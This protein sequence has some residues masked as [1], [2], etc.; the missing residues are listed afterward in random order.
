VAGGNS[1]TFTI[2]DL[3]DGRRGFRSTVNA[4][5]PAGTIYGAEVIE[6]SAGDGTVRLVLGGAL[7][8]DWI[9][10][11]GTQVPRNSNVLSLI[12]GS[13]DAFSASGGQTTWTWNQVS[14]NL[15]NASDEGQTTYLE[16]DGV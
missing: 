6:F 3:G 5:T 10:G 2:T 9:F 11:A 14:G 16:V 8:Q 12:P 4:L 13:A 15:F 7:P 1:Q